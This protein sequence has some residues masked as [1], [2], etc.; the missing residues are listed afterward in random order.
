KA[1]WAQ[2]QTLRKSKVARDVNAA[3]TTF[4]SLVAECNKLAGSIKAVASMSLT[5]AQKTSRNKLST[6]VS[7]FQKTLK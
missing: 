3:R 7:N 5:T 4:A 1:Q 2:V 6:D